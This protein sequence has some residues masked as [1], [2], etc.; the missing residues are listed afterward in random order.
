MLPP[1][2]V[3]YRLKISLCGVKPAVWRRVLA[4]GN[5]ALRDLHRVIQVAMGW[6]DA[7][8]H[9]FV[10]DGKRYGVPE[11]EGGAVVGDERRIRLSEVAPRK[12][13]AFTYE[14]D[15]LGSRWK[16]EVRVERIEAAPD[17]LRGPCCLGGRRAC[18]PEDCGGP[19]R[20]AHL[21]E[22]LS[23]PDHPEH[24]ACRLWVGGDFDASA[25]DSDQVNEGLVRNGPRARRAD[26]AWLRP[27]WI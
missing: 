20:Y 25:F 3:V 1:D 7:H 26:L 11:S 18:P 13:E 5:L 2:A 12:G 6:R 19:A 10:V 17:G 9:L 23:D 24:E 8:L 15:L 16:H 27:G 22:I 21:L 14:Y 4:P